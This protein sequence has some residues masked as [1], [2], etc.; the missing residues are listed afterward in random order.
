[1]KSLFILG[2]LFLS[3]AGCLQS[4]LSA[5]TSA[6]Q[7]TSTIPSNA[8]AAKVVLLFDVPSEFLDGETGIIVGAD[9]LSGTIRKGMVTT[10]NGKQMK[11]NFI[12]L[13]HEYVEQTKKGE[14]PSIGLTNV[15]SKDEL[16]KGTV[17]TFE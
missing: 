8:N 12:K 9:V 3:M 1:M 16:P 15:T 5:T 2:I 13:K 6:T 4:G 17:L 11:V 10:F 14:F 7:D